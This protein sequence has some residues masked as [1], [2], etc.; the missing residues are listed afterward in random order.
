MSRPTATIPNPAFYEDEDVR[1]DVLAGCPDLD[2]LYA[3]LP[4]DAQKLPEAGAWICVMR[5]PHTEITVPALS[6]WFAKPFYRSRKFRVGG[7]HSSTGGRRRWVSW[8]LLR[9]VVQTPEG[10]LHLL[11]TEYQ[12]LRRGISPL[13][14]TVGNGLTMHWLDEH[15]ADQVDEREF[16][17]RTRGFSRRD[18][19][20]LLLPDLEDQ[21][22]V[23]FTTDAP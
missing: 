11:P 4:D 21:G 8:P 9:A 12:R 20:T 18:A 19:L 16:Y 3:A 15:A 2:T 5:E 1:S 23:Y 13:L 10:E 14:D 17:L 22:F 7:Q 6:L